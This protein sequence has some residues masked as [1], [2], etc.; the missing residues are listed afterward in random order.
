VGGADTDLI[1]GDT[2]VDFKTTKDGTVTAAILDQSLV[3]MVANGILCFG[4]RSR[5]GS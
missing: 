2:L 3:T 1:A 4:S 5:S